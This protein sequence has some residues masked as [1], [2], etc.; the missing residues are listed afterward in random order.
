M[1][2]CSYVILCPVR[3]APAVAGWL[4]GFSRTPTS[5]CGRVK[6]CTAGTTCVP[7]G[8]PLSPSSPGTNT[9]RWCTSLHSRYVVILTG[10]V[11]FSFNMQ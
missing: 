9:M 2:D 11:I 7:A 5:M 3:A 8:L 4:G 10:D 1:S 6:C